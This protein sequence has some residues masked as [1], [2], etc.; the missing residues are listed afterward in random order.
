MDKRGGVKIFRR[1]FFVSQCHKLSQGSLFVL[2]FRKLPAAQR[3]MDKKGGYHDFP[4]KSFLNH[5]P[6]KFGKGNFL[7]CVSENF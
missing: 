7:C 6:E 2:C 5:N 4:S 1:K 3:I